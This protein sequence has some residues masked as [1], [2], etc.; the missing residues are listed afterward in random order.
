MTG[1]YGLVKLEDIDIA[2]NKALLE[3]I[4][5]RNNNLQLEFCIQLYN[6][7]R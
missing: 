3:M 1:L 5:A 2:E 7:R 6:N 4:N